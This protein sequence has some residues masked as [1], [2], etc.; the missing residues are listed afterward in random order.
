VLGDIA[1][2]CGSKRLNPLV[3][4]ENYFGPASKPNTALCQL[5]E[6]LRRGMAMHRLYCRK[7]A[8]DNNSALVQALFFVTS[9]IYDP[10]KLTERAW[11]PQ[12]I[13]G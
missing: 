6:R 5:C 12:Q 11:Q 4:M 13:Q 9:S 2:I 1:R 3:K 7:P 8:V 10:R